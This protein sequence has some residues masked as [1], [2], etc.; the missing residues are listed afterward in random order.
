MI[1]R[2]GQRK[3]REMLAG[4]A[5]LNDILDSLTALIQEEQPGS[6]CSILLLDEKKGCLTHASAPDLPEEYIGAIN[7]VAIGPSVGSCG[8]AAYSAK[9][10]VVEDI[11]THPYWE[12][13]KSIALA[14]GLKACWSQPIF[15][16][17][18]KVL[19][20]FA[21]YYRHLKSPSIEEIE[22][23]ITASELAGLAIEWKQTEQRLKESEEEFRSIFDQTSSGIAVLDLS[24]RIIRTNARFCQ[25]AGRSENELLHKSIQEITHPDDVEKT[26]NAL[27]TSLLKGIS[28]EMDKRYVLPDSSIVWVRISANLIRDTDGSPKYYVGIC[29]DITEAKNIEFN[30]QKL[31]G[32]VEH[33][34][35]FIGIAG[36]DSMSVYVNPA[37]MKLLGFD[38]PEDYRNASIADYYMP[39]FYP[40]VE[41]ELIPALVSVGL[42]SGEVILKNFKTAEAINVY[43]N[44]FTIK[45]AEGSPIGYACFAQDI[46]ERLSREA[47]YQALFNAA[48]DAILIADDEG[49]Y[50][51]INPS[52][53]RK[54]G[55]EPSRVIGKTVSELFFQNH[56]NLFQAR[57]E[58]FLKSGSG[59]GDIPY[60]CP[61]GTKKIFSFSAIANYLPGRHLSSMRDV[62]ASREAEA[63]LKRAHDYTARIIQHSPAL[64]CGITLSGETIFINEAVTLATGYTEEELIGRNWWEVF[65]PGDYYRQVE[66]LFSLFGGGNVSDY[67]MTLLDKHGEERIVS[68]TSLNTYG[69]N[70]ELELISGFGIDVTSL[71]AAQTQVEK[72]QAELERTV[73]ERTQEL[74]VANNQ[75]KET[76][77]LRDTF[78][79]ALTHDLKTPLVAQRRLLDVLITQQT[80]AQNSFVVNAMLKNN[81]ALLAMVTKLL[82][83]Y[84]YIDGKS[85]LQ[86]ETFDLQDLV[87][88]CYSDLVAIATAEDISLSKKISKDIEPLFADR[89]LLKRV[90][91]NLLGNA[92]ENIPEG[93]DICI[94]AETIHQEVVIQVTDNGPGIP[95][96]ILPNLFSRYFARSSTRK[97]GSGL[98]L[99]ICKMIMELHGGSIEVTNIQPQGAQFTLKLPQK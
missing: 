11:N 31:I 95:D 73:E 60:V 63:A 30:H 25:I 77:Q 49:R 55:L 61:D 88:E 33:C 66:T 5:S 76:Q 38:T 1:F 65:Y 58:E 2:I 18:G 39:E 4:R 36:L 57:W 72:V 70:E 97:I 14:H 92:L 54:L 79:S 48:Q 9:R 83:T 29:Q 51:N 44:A 17:E 90:F 99:F 15:S 42:W 93:S 37:G 34:Q 53:A 13:Y 52:A 91:I 96:E 86:L 75:L 69:E 74:L 62:T 46:R 43:L 64:I 84:A 22:L 85:Q 94:T 20:T 24:M 59:S 82:E 28:Y 87:D 50:L 8:A 16:A 41:R 98:G 3:I 47:E 6:I 10:V 80:E 89:G 19:G 32:V 7:G 21:I 68:W 23:L 26:Q 71:R 78:V 40:F 56:P 45:D 27:E 67:E 12:A 81:E 35:D